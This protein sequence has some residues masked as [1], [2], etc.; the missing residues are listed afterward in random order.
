M[1]DGA[2]ICGNISTGD[3]NNFFSKLVKAANEGENL[4]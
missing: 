3:A 2:T 4:P 1:S